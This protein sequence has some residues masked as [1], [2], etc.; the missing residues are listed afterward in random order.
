MKYADDGSGKFKCPECGGRWFRTTDT[1]TTAL[2]RGGHP[3][4]CKDE[5]SVGCQWKGLM[6]RPC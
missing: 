3:V 5:L 2:G 6:R 4:Q 1:S